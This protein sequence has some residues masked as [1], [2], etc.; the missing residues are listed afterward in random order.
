MPSLPTAIV[1][2][3]PPCASRLGMCTL[4]PLRLT[5][6]DGAVRRL[7]QTTQDSPRISA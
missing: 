2:L 1:L 3:L 6:F 4:R 7:D 5:P